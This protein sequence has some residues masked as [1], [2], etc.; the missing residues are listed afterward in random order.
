MKQLLAIFLLIAPCAWGQIRSTDVF[1]QEI[2]TVFTL[3]DGLPA[4]AVT[5]IFLD[6]SENPIAKT[7]QGYYWLQGKT[8]TSYT[9]EVKDR[10]PQNIKSLPQGAGAVLSQTNFGNVL[11]VGTQNGLFMK[12][13]KSWK[14]IFPSDAN[15][16]WKLS[17]VTILQVDDKNRLWVGSDQGVGLLDNNQWKLFTG[18]EGL[19]YTKFTCS[20]A[21][22]QGAIWLGTEKGAIRADGSRFYYRFSRRWL[23]DDFVNDIA[24]QKDGTTWIATNKGVSRIGFKEMSYEEK[25]LHFVQQVESRH[26]RE[27]FI[28]QNKLNKQYDINSYRLDISDNDGMY[29]A[30]YGASQAFR[31]A[32]TKEKEAKELA[33][34]SLKACKWLVDI[35]HEAG[36]PARV[37]I[38][39]DWEDPVNEIYDSLYNVNHQKS[40]P[41]W[42]QILP[43]F[44][45]SKDGRHYW[46]C[47]TSS[48]EL[49]GHYF[50]YAVFYDLV[51]ETEEEKQLVR[52]VVAD[53]TDHLVRNGFLLRDHDGKPTRWGNFSPEF[54]NSIWGWDQRGLNAM[55]MLS[56][57]NVAQHVTGDA[58]YAETSKMLRDQYNYHIHAMQSKAFFPPEDVVPWDNNLCLMSM[59]G[60]IKY[61]KDPELLMMYRESAEFSWEHISKQNNAFWNIIYAAIRDRFNEVVETG[62]YSSGK[63]FPEAGPYA[64]FTANEF[65]GSD[66]HYDRTM[67]TL[68]QLPLDLIGY[69]M[70]N[71]HRLDIIHDPT[72]GA[73]SDKGWH[74][75]GFALPIDER[76][77][78]RQDRDAFALHYS[79]GGGY[80]EQEGTFYLLPYYM[81][82]YHGYI[83]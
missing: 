53:V 30:M 56:F 78:V 33:V 61:E 14:E 3:E 79:E 21:G 34:R 13:K 22:R 16:S 54:L 73:P 2:A 42:K 59:Y 27:G 11:Y 26:N 28:C 66:Y 76:G 10:T 70:D 29:T 17:N 24:V 44:V 47:D 19:P 36:F 65:R 4:T 39:V 40:D 41:F 35:T 68:T 31:Y 15:Y 81:A 7:S 77:H 6:E 8:W 74:Y 83:K 1:D 12:E 64:P 45:K 52:T 5:S 60:L 58:R 38:P 25:A 43:R 37:I 82:L 57:L 69:E 48:D 55:M 80:S 72:P 23:P 9:K 62:V 46:K 71:T 51:A 63:V 32:V 75:D 49:A 18:A 20:H 50:F 67:A